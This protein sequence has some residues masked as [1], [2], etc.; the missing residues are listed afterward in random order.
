MANEVSASSMREDKPYDESFRENADIFAS[1]EKLPDIEFERIIR[2]FEHFVVADGDAKLLFGERIKRLY[3]VF[4]WKYAL[5]TING[6]FFTN[7]TDIPQT[8]ERVL[9]CTDVIFDN[10]VYETVS[11]FDMEECKNYDGKKYV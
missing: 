11:K 7:A 3:D 1:L 5:T 10:K 8:A 9:I 6:P 4:V 2:L